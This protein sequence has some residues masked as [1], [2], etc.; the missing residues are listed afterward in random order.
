MRVQTL[1]TAAAENL[2]RL[3]SALAVLLA[4]LLALLGELTAV[5]IS[6]QSISQPAPPAVKSW[7]EWRHVD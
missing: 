5:T 6:P 2:K 7:T 4:P 1:L 3:A